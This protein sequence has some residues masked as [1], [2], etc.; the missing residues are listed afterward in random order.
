MRSTPFL[1]LGPNHDVLWSIPDVFI[2][3]KTLAAWVCGALL[4]DGFMRWPEGEPPTNTACPKCVLL[5]ERISILTVC[6][7]KNQTNLNAPATGG[8]KTVSLK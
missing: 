4:G 8:S 5:F 6:L 1:K 2:L 3:I 7:F